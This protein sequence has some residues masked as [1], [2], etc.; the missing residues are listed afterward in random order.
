MEQKRPSDSSQVDAAGHQVGPRYGEAAS[1]SPQRP[2]TRPLQLLVSWLVAALAVLVAGAIV[3]GVSVPNVGDAILAAALIAI[4][5]ALL[6]PLVAALRLPLTLALGFVLVLLLD[7]LVLLLVS[8]IAPS[9]IKVDSFG[10]A[11]LASIVMAAASVV[12]QVI[13]GADDDD[14]YTLRV[15]KRIARW[16]TGRARPSISRKTIPG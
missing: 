1:W 11:L 9:A 2:R 7:A 12:L 13:F 8:D 4:L 3:P 10:D 16:R 14:T 15:T 5:N 6:P